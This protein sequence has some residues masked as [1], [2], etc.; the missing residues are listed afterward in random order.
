MA[1]SGDIF[2]IN[3]VYELIQDDL[4]PND[5]LKKYGWYGSGT[6]SAGPTTT[7]SIINRLSFFSD[8][9]LALIRGPLSLARRGLGSTGNNNDGWFG[10]GNASIPSPLAR[11]RIDR[12]NFISDTETAS[13]RGSLST[14]RM[15]LDAVSDKNY[16]WFIGGSIETTSVPSTS[17]VSVV[18]RIN[19]TD[20]TVTASARG[21]LTQGRKLLTSTGNNNFGWV[22]GG[23]IYT[24]TG[25][26]TCTIERITFSSDTT[27]AS[28]RGTLSATRESLASHSNDNFGWVFGGE[29]TIYQSTVERINFSQDTLTASV[30]GSLIT[31]RFLLTAEGTINE[32]WIAG[33]RSPTSPGISIIE[34]FIFSSDTQIASNRSNLSVSLTSLNAT[35]GII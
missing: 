11:S 10:G 1:I 19:F 9:E 31:A 8:T 12:I 33:G 20:D 32:S 30:R 5:F 24:T 4:W 27:T 13:V 18:D 35:S 15:S 28:V 23:E 26:S 17:Y 29:P 21:N 16:G 2:R 7:T 22:I 3:E 14:I 6:P 34:R 25:I